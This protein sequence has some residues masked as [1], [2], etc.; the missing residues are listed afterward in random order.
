MKNSAELTTV[1]CVDYSP[2][3][4][5]S[6][7]PRSALRSEE[8][9]ITVESSLKD[10]ADRVRSEHID[11]ILVDLPFSAA[12]DRTGIDAIRKWRPS[13]PIVAVSY[14]PFEGRYRAELPQGARFADLIISP[15]SSGQIPH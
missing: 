3:S 14:V 10:A 15:D 11:A 13:V 1:L 5:R 4:A 8:I 9:W 6:E 12:P 2:S 7:H